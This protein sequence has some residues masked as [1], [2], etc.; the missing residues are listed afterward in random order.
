MIID[1][2]LMRSVVLNAAGAALLCLGLDSGRIQAIFLKDGTWISTIIVLVFAYGL[3][4]CLYRHWE[5]SRD[6]NRRRR[7]KGCRTL[8]WNAY[9]LAC[10]QR[11]G[12][13][14]VAAS[15]L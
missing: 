10:A 5:V 11:L 4:L 9:T 2:L 14:G 8:S 15:S 12:P 6:L 3:S 13:I 1:L 7:N